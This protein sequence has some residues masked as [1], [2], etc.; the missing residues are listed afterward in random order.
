MAKKL[1]NVNIFQEKGSQYNLKMNKSICQKW[2]NSNY[3]I[4]LD[5]IMKTIISTI[6]ISKKLCN[7]KIHQKILK[8]YKIQL[9]KLANMN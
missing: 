4:F 7:Y 1:S 2:T 8:N 5:I 6:Y 3:L 9:L